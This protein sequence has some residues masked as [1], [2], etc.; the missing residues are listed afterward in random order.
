MGRNNKKDTIQFLH[1]SRGSAYEV[2]TL[3][4]IAFMISIIDEQVYQ[5]A[6]KKI[7]ALYVLL[8]YL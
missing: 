6:C 1:V 8:T 2:D 3:L 5:E 4:S 7:E